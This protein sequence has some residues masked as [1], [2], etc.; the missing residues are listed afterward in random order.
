MTEIRL[1]LT[2]ERFNALK[3]KHW[4]TFRKLTSGVFAG[5]IS[6]RMQAGNISMPDVVNLFGDLDAI[7]DLLAV[8]MADAN[9]NYLPES[10]A[11]DLLDGMGIEEIS[12]LTEK[13]IGGAGEL[14]LPKANETPSLEPSTAA[15]ETLPDGRI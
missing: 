15:P 7:C 4:R 12:H 11:Q 3:R 1:R 14:A 6:A 5:D 2:Q 13:W 8:F 10:E 9:G